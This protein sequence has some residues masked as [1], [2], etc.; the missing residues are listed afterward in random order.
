MPGTVDDLAAV[1]AEDDLDA[2]S[3]GVV[4]LLR[5][6][7]EK[8]RATYLTGEGFDARRRLYAARGRVFALISGVKDA[9]V[10]VIGRLVALASG[11]ARAD[12]PPSPD[13]DASL[14]Q[15]IGSWQAMDLPGYWDAVTRYARATGA[16]IA[17]QVLLLT[18]LYLVV[19][20]DKAEA[21]NDPDPSAMELL[22]AV[23]AAWLGDEPDQIYAG[24]ATLTRDG[25]DATLAFSTQVAL[26][27]LAG[28]TLPT[29]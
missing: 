9:D 12:D 19:A 14:R 24:C 15:A 8:L 28:V 17:E 23:N 21:A 1:S 18:Y 13:L 2:V 26:L 7:L 22:A 20:S 27:I 3:A 25:A 10:T 11:T 6:Q 5:W 29:D 4:Q 16:S